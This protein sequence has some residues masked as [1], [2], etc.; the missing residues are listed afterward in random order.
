MRNRFQNSASHHE[1][2]LKQFK[3]KCCCYET[4]L[5][6]VDPILKNEQ[7]IFCNFTMLIQCVYNTSQYFSNHETCNHITEELFF[8]KF[9]RYFEFYSFY[10]FLYYFKFPNQLRTKSASQR[11]KQQQVKYSFLFNNKKISEK[12]AE[13]KI[14]VC[15]S[16]LNSASSS[17]SSFFKTNFINPQKTQ[18]IERKLEILKL[19]Q[20]K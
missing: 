1:L 4:L 12:I 18:T 6:L 5:L 13:V 11:N 3:I 19:V 15:P 8:L 9:L 16:L 2:L 7:N 20:I 17:F 10:L 14:Q